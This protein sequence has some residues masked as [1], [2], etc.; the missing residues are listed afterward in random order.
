[1]SRSLTPAEQQTLAQLRSEIDAIALQATRLQL[2]STTVLAGPTPGPDYTVLHTRFQQLGL[3]LG[4]LVNRGLV[5]VEESLDPAM[6]AN[7][8]ISRGANP[9]VERL[10]LRPGLLVGANETS[11]TAR[12]II[13]I[14]ELSHALFEHPLHPVK[15]YAYRAGWAWGYLPAALAESNADTFAEA[16]ALT[17][18]RMQQRWGRYQA[19]GRVPAQRFAL[20]KARGV[21]DLGAA[22]AYADIH[23]NRAW[24]RAND[25]K[26]MALSDHRKDKWPGIKAGWQAEPDFTG[27][28]TIESRLQSL[29]LIGPRE[30]GILLNGLTSTDKA[31][32][33]GV[34]AYTAAL[35]DALA[36]ANPTPTQA[37]QTV[38]YDPAT[39]RLLLPHAVAGAGAVPLAKQIIDA[40]ITATPV[41][42]TMPKAFA[43]HRS[44]IVDLLVA[45]DRP[46]EL[47]AL[48]PLRALF[49]A[50]PAT[51]PTPA[52]WQD[53][54][55]DLLIAA[56]TDI[57]GRWE[58]TA[59]RAVDAA[60]G[61]AAERPALATL[62]QA[63]AEDIDRAAA[64]RKELPSTE[65]EFR[66]MSIA[67]DT[68]TAAV[69]TLYPARKAAYEALQQRL[70]PF[71]PGAGIL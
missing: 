71:L 62:D 49:A 21:T 60:I 6:A 70:K 18:E 50:T 52:Q 43:L 17:A 46:T 38:V 30:D 41:P 34:Y 40:L 39:K 2:T 15:D 44:T 9:T 33:V 8:V 16:A 37:G 56:I 25:A 23:L 61:P 20:A 7:T 12:A 47:A 48:G 36:G 28:L 14:H 22:L 11:V 66:K 64:I 59:V 29:G 42:A 69:V 65:Q 68:V 55:F 63:L 19:L 53:L 31:T 45:N 67:L 51:R 5:V 35:K 57:S 27:L 54:A 1:M 26:G 4:E 58:R 3:R 32:V 10:E 24:L 13:L